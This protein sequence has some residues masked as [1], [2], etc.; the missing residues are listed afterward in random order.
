ML[1]SRSI[2]GAGT[3]EQFFSVGL[4]RCGHPMFFPMLGSAKSAS[5]VTGLP[6]Y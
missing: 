5:Q 4:V 3:I 1:A 2:A 6:K